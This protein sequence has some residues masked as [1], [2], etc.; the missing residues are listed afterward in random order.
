MYKFS[1]FEFSIVYVV[2]FVEET[3]TKDRKTKKLTLSNAFSITKVKINNII[4]LLLFCE[5]D[6]F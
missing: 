4:F 5:L 1:I 6:T 3:M 2:F